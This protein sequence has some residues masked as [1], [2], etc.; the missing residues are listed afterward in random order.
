MQI[1]PERPVFT[2]GVV[3]E[4]LGLNPRAIRLYEEMGLICPARS[5]GRTRLY[6]Q[7]DI[8]VLQ[9]IVYLTRVEK[10]NLAGVRL[11]L[12]MEEELRV[13]REGSAPDKTTE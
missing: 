8:E 7:K 3:S 5:K 1:H 10:V 4:L 11:I 6:S 2:I 9:R 12:Q 13:M